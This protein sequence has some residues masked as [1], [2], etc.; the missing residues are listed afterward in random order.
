L[1]AVRSNRVKSELIVR[2]PAV[3]MRRQVRE[4]TIALTVT[5]V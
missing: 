5:E 4:L 3:Q 1:Y 2:E